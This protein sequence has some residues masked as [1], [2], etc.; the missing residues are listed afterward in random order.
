MT[1]DAEVL[2]GARPGMQQRLDELLEE[3]RQVRAW[4]AL[5]VP[6]E[7]ERY[8]ADLQ[9]GIVSDL[10]DL[11]ARWTEGG[12]TL[13]LAVP[14]EME[15]GIARPAD[16][17]A[18]VAQ[19]D[20]P[21]EAAQADQAAEV[22]AD[23]VAEVMADQVAEVPPPEPAEATP[24]EG[25]AEG[26]TPGEESP[27][28]HR[29]AGEAPAGGAAAPGGTEE[30]RRGASEQDEKPASR[31]ASLEDLRRLQQV[32]QQGMV[33]KL[34]TPD[35]HAQAPQGV[36]RLLDALEGDRSTRRLADRVVQAAR[37]IDR[38][39]PA[40]KAVQQAIVGYLATWLRHIQDE[41]PEQAPS[42]SALDKAFA[43]LTRFSKLQEPGYVNGLMREHRPERGSWWEDAQRWRR[44]LQKLV[45]H[46]PQDDEAPT[47][48]ALLREVEE[49]ELPLEQVDAIRRALEGG[50]SSK[51]PRL[52][53][54]A[55]PLLSQGHLDGPD[56]KALRKAIRDHLSATVE[57]AE[58]DA[59]TE[60][61]GS[62]ADASWPWLAVTRGRRAL[63]VGGDEREP[64]RQRIQRA[65]ELESLEW[66][67]EP[68]PR[69]LQAQA[70]RIRRGSID[71]VLQLIQFSGH[72]CDH[73]LAPA[74][75]EAGIPFVRVNGGYGL[76]AIRRS[77]EE[78]V[79]LPEPE[80]GNSSLAS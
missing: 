5:D 3:F 49:A 39:R 11:L 7:L 59:T 17:A 26:T 79:R 76:G 35:G 20:E 42:A 6:E 52:V 29:A 43:A 46:A 30:A 63:I 4:M 73:H 74:C 9:H 69:S 27:P 13:R 34:E 53:K 19:G 45:G 65:L 18:Q 72:D 38:F 22:M 1:L 24:V 12:G 47:P 75:K 78:Q 36:I 54:L 62:D 2:E 15:E 44:R 23:Q 10:A 51:D 50:V 57:D 64:A 60:A 31:P 8:L 28:A 32:F 41:A 67:D 40:S 33:Y 58:E 56:L 71:L 55:A 37:D 25:P 21:A 14:G 77:I 48:E 70:E 66:I 68:G 80:S 61:T 16:H